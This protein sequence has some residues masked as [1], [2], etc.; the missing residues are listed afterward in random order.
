MLVFRLPI[1]IERLMTAVFMPRPLC[2]SP[3]TTVGE[4][5]IH[6]AEIA[7]G[8]RAKQ[9]SVSFGWPLPIVRCYLHNPQRF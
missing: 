9:M 3:S 4:L 2:R 1:V 7:I 6:D 8:P 5:F